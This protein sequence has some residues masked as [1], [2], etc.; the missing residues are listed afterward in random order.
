V[1]TGYYG[2]GNQVKKCTVSSALTAV[3]Q[4]IALACDANPN[5]VRGS[6]CL[7]RLLQVM[8]D[9]YRKVDPPTQKKLP[10]QADVPEFLLGTSYQD[11]TPQQHKATVDITSI[12]FY[13]LLQVGE[14]MVRA[15]E[16]T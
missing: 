15:R 1:C 3:G 14:Y 12:A 6:E 5:K 7:L 10:V 16:T 11:G 13:Y 2:K 4:K 9:G 8:L